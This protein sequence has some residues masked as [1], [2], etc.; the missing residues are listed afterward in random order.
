MMPPQ[1]GSASTSG[2]IRRARALACVN[3][4][5]WFHSRKCFSV[6]VTREAHSTRVRSAVG[7]HRS[8]ANKGFVLTAG[9]GLDW[10]LTSAIGIRLFQAEYLYSQF[11]NGG[12]Y[13]N[14]QNN[15]R[16]SAGIVLN[17]H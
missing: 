17:F 11:Q 3:T 5:P 15:L 1:I 8:G 2:V 9:G 14:H 16:I 10:K 6:P 13:G 7:S 4:T 12:T